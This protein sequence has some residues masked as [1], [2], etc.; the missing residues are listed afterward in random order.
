MY[1]S[2]DRFTLAA[3]L[4]FVK[5]LLYYLVRMSEAII[6]PDGRREAGERTRER[7]VDAT[8]RLI[9]EH[10]EAG[11]SLRAITEAAGANVASVS[12]H[13]GS[14]EAL[15]NAAVEQSLDRF[16]Q[17]QIEALR[18][19][20]NPTLDDIALAWTQPIVRAVAASPCPEQLFMRV[21]GRTL[22]TCTGDR[23][24]RVVRQA[25]PV[26]EEL[27]R[28][29]RHV[30]PALAERE[31]RFRVAAA[32]SIAHFV[33]TGQAGLDGRP[34]EEIERLLVPVVAGALAGGGAASR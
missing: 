22:T 27:V 31:L 14:K 26:E 29:L 1:K 30:L 5:R 28:A 4:I 13:F 21:V 7:L 32:G 16:M 17:D 11:I 19:L 2:I 15:V 33:T 23:L 9:A 6:T 8:R 25:A 10:G 20:E 34:A 18:A 12:Y 3:D 24:D